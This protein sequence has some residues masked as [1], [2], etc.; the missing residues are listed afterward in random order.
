MDPRNAVQTD[1]KYPYGCRISIPVV[2]DLPRSTL[3]SPIAFLVRAVETRTVTLSSH[4]SFL[5]LETER[6]ILQCLQGGPVRS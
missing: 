1:R 2:D 6:P 4:A 5:P 3:I